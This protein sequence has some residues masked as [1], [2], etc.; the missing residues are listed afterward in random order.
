MMTSM[1]G[2]DKSDHPAYVLV[3]KATYELLEGPDWGVNVDLCDLV[4]SDF[5]RFG[6]DAVKALKL[7]MLKTPMKPA[8]QLLA[9]TA[10]EMCMKNC[11]AQFH[12]M[13][14]AKEVL[15]EMSKLALTARC[16]TEVRRKT[17]QLL[18]EWAAQL[19]IP[20][21]A[22]VY[23]GLR[24][25]GVEFPGADLATAA[26]MHTP[27]QTV[28]RAAAL[29]G[30]DTIDEADAA[31]IRQAVAEADAEVAAEDATRRGQQQQHNRQQREQRQQ[32]Q[33]TRAHPSAYRLPTAQPY[34]A[35]PTGYAAVP[36]PQ[37]GGEA[38]GGGG[39]NFGG[40]SGGGVGGGAYDHAAA[41]AAVQTAGT[42]SEPPPVDASSPD[43][44]AKLTE[45]LNIAAG[46]VGLLVDMLDSIDPAGNPGAVNDE[47]VS[48]LAEQCGQM[49]PRVVA[50]VQSVDDEELVMAA[51]SLNDSL[52]EALD[53]R[54]MLVAA[55]AADP[56]TRAVIAASMARGSAVAAGSSDRPVR[57]E[58]GGGLVDALDEF[59]TAAPTPSAS[60][61]LLNVEMGFAGG[62]TAAVGSNGRLIV[63]PPVPPSS[64][65]VVGSPPMTRGPASARAVV[66]T[67]A[68]PPGSSSGTPAVTFDDLLGE[69]PSAVAPTSAA[70]S[71]SGYG[72]GP[73]SG[74]MSDPFAMG[75]GAPPTDPFSASL[76]I[77]NSSNSAGRMDL[78]GGDGTG[79]R[80]AGSSTNP[81]GAVLRQA[82]DEQQ[83]RGFGMI[84]PQPY[85]GIA[86]NDSVNPL[87]DP[88]VAQ[89]VMSMS[90][91]GR[92]GGGAGGINDPFASLSGPSL[93]S[94]AATTR[95][96]P[97]STTTNPFLSVPHPAQQQQGA[98][99]Q[100][101]GQGQRG[102][103]SLM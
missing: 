100:G 82:H 31:A 70:S 88:D 93:S 12:A 29:G 62:G 37:Y 68:P 69:M 10:L 90:M 53:K 52:S 78:A 23:N 27:Q 94:P 101:Q 45:D 57:A 44:I 55:A 26:P 63:P 19:R 20:Q 99:E 96:P 67:L 56:G 74:V 71:G 72:T 4:N 49:R 41:L 95:P 48:E 47:A 54:D 7:K 33:G 1:F 102:Q 85:G 14:V 28:P 98:Q 9:L 92:A 60:V 2:G 50:L 86:M 32:Q 66:P 5:H 64:A 43:A 76:P 25:K 3:G 16:D 24:N 46:V 15:G 91:G 21:Y 73:S 83:G 77:P 39:G 36:P 13:V 35:L 103:P 34:G 6:K 8:V 75:A 89:G 42:S 79:S 22:E 17:L 97:A 11:G 51:L 81:F 84:P 61:D 38:Y 80:G 87:F 30:L 18:E 59:A 65:P 40:E 58:E